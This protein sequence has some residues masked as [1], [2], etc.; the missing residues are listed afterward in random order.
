MKCANC[1]AEIKLG[2]VYCSV[3]GKEA[4]I[5][6]DYNVEEDILKELL[7]E[8]D[9]PS[10]NASSN[11]KKKKSLKN[12]QKKKKEAEQKKKQKQKRLLITVSVLIA[13]AIIGVI[14]VLLVQNSHKKSFDYQYQKGISYT[15]EKN[16]TKALT[17]FEQAEKLQPDNVDVLLRM[18]DLY[19]LR[20]D[21]T[22][23]EAY[24]LQILT[25]DKNNEEAYQ[26]LIALYD[27]QKEYDKLQD[28]YEQSDSDKIKALFDNYEVKA[29]EFSEEAGEYNDT[30]EIELMADSDCTIYYTLNGD[31][32]IEKGMEYTEPISLEDEKEYTIKAV[33]KDAR[34]FYSE[35]AEADYEITF[36]APDSANVTPAAGTYYDAQ[37]ISIQVP[38]GSTAYYTWDG[39]TPT[40]ASHLY[41]QPIKVPEG[42]NILSV[43]IIDHTT[44]LS[45]DVYRG[46]FIYYSQDYTAEDDIDDPADNAEE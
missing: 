19:R 44:K 20:K 32:P 25:L 39:S 43:V 22:S 11:G 3:C 27:K 35:I 46:N 16:Y 6:P 30:I 45:S 31:S 40:A 29:P 37:S 4:Q 21:E 42:N 38:A 12:S 14:I 15:E 2:C 17:Y 23:E 5:V 7:E 41:T 13:I 18:A 36:E 1:G 28:L 33:A 24:L 9:K 26:M 8:D 34:G 10:K